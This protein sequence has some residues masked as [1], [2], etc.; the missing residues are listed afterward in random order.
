MTQ[1]HTACRRGILI[2]L[3][4]LALQELPR[5]EG[6]EDGVAAEEGLWPTTAYEEWLRARLR[7]A[8]WRSHV[9]CCSMLHGMPGGPAAEEGEAAKAAEAPAAAAMLLDAEEGEEGRQAMA[10]PASGA[11]S[12][13]SKGWAEGCMAVS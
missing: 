1:F 5:Q 7:Y 12:T 2:A 6:G 10:P 8:L 4:G 3:S 9:A 13:A 11:V